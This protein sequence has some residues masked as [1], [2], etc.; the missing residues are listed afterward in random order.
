[1]KRARQ[2]N[3][4]LSDAEE[5]RL[6]LLAEHYGLTAASV[7][8]MLLKREADAQRIDMQVLHDEEGIGR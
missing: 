3:V 1:M 2:I 4:R 6:V 7:I 8:R 5:D